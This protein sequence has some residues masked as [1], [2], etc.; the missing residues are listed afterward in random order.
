MQG[1]FAKAQAAGVKVA[2][3]TDS[4]VS[5]HG[6]NAQEAVLMSEAGMSNEAIL[7]SA[8]V[9]AADL[10]DM[11]DSIGTLE[12]GKYADI[13]A[14]D[15]SAL[16]DIEELLD[17]DFVMKGGRFTRTNKSVATTRSLQ[18]VLRRSGLVAATIYHVLRR[19]D[20]VVVIIYH[21][22][23]RSDRVVATIYFPA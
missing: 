15:G 14:T 21:V 18:Q 17:V 3:G 2:F 9:N 4:G 13:I 10:L 5:P 7:I 23:R 1:N 22:L 20:R 8:T 16:E 19:S 6:E 12:A 11:S